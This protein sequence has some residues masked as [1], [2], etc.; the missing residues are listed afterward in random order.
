MSIPGWLRAALVAALL[1]VCACVAFYT[2][3]S[4]SLS[5]QMTDVQEKLEIDLKRERKQQT[6]YDAAAE[7]LPA[8]R[9]QLAALKP[10]VTAMQEQEAQLREQRKIDRAAY[11][12]LQQQ[13]SD[14]NSAL[15][16]AR[17][18]GDTAA[19]AA[20]AALLDAAAALEE[21]PADE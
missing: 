13:L 20:A 18:A 6:E 1:C 21:V 3:R 5:A 12:E 8:A 11:T 4:Q 9:E 19:A 7:A 10:Q 2:V 14:T 16:A 15:A 17:Q